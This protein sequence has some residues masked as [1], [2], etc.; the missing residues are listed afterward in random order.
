[1]LEATCHFFPS[2]D[3]WADPICPLFQF[4]SP[5]TEAPNLP[6]SQE[7][8]FQIAATMRSAKRA[9]ACTNYKGL[10]KHWE[11]ALDDVEAMEKDP[12]ITWR[13]ER[14]I[15]PEQGSDRS[16]ITYSYNN[17]TTIHCH[18]FLSF[19][20]MRLVGVKNLYPSLA[21]LNFTNNLLSFSFLHKLIFS[22]IYLHYPFP[23][24]T[25]LVGGKGS[26][27]LGRAVYQ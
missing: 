25:R 13:E 24:F 12:T 27:A 4:G 22:T 8:K 3:D 9:T 16:H 17:L 23:P 11:K 21:W 6:S 26:F 18:S 15:A 5:P 14:R 20:S 2:P 7:I 1:V 19:I 10:A